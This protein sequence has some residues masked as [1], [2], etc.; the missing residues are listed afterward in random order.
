MVD[1]TL[2]NRRLYSALLEKA[3]FVVQTAEDGFRALEKIDEFTPSLILLDYMMPNLD[4]ISVLERLRRDPK[5]TTLPVVMLTSSAEPDHID[6]ALEAGANDYITKPVNGKILIARVKSMIRA[7]KLRERVEVGSLQ[8]QLVEE[9]EE[10]AR[11]QQAQ[12][13]AVPILLDDWRVTGVVLPSGQV[14]GDIFDVVPLDDGSFVAMLLDV[15]GHGTASALIAAETRA[16][17]KNLIL[18]RPLEDALVRL[19]Q[20][21]ARRQTGKYCC[22]AA[23]LVKDRTLTLVNAGLP[24]AVVLRGRK[25]VAS[26]WGSGLPIGMFDESSYVATTLEVEPGDRV[27]LLSDGLTEP[28]GV[29]DNSA[30]AVERLELWPTVRNEVPSSQELRA[31]INRETLKDNVQ[32]DDDRTVVVLQLSGAIAETMRMAARPDAIARAVRWAVDRCPNWVDRSAIDHGLTEAL[33]NAVIHGALGLTSDM[34]RQGGYEDFLDLAASLPTQP[35]Y[36]DRHVE[37]EVHQNQ[38]QVSIHI[39]WRGDSCPVDAQEPESTPPSGGRLSSFEGVGMGTTLIY[40]LFDMV[41]WDNDGL[42]MELTVRRAPN[43]PPSP[44]FRWRA[45]GDV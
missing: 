32:A 1:D 5:T 11:V 25:V 12:L 18:G 33:T 19:N 34:R 8:T 36:V 13:P 21:M 35:G 41:S 42:G 6:R 15:S 17:L 30:D 29:A 20:H 14:G 31:L 43:S 4:G 22:L 2:A 26:V 24:P 7:D 27:I 9:L 16:E 40:S 39:R 10:A 3:G 38:E 28:F 45:V 23:V 44:Q 37:L